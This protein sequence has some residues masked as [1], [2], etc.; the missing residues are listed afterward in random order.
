MYQVPLLLLKILSCA[1]EKHLT[2]HRFWV[3]NCG[4]NFV[5]AIN[6]K[7]TL[8]IGIQRIQGMHK[9]LY[10]NNKNF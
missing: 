10:S 2:D 1:F 5:V 4:Q 3:I 9:A 6:I 8:K 7:N